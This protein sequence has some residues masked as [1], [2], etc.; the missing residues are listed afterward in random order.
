MGKEIKY[1][2]DDLPAFS[3][4]LESL[5]APPDSERAGSN[6][7]F[8]GAG[9]SF[10]A[11]K[12]A[13]YLSEFR[14]RALDPYDLLLNPRIAEGKHV[15]MISISG[16]TRTNIEAAKA[17]RGIARRITAITSDVRSVLAET[18]DDLIKLNFRKTGAVTPGT[19]SFTTTLLA[20]Y[21]R[22]RE[23]PAI[24]DLRE[25]FDSCVSWSDTI[26]LPTEGTV[27]IVG[28]GVSY[29][30]AIYG[31]AKIF[32]VLGSRS[33]YQAT[34]QF[35][36]MELFS[37]SGGDF[38]LLIPRSGADE[39]VA[40]LEG[41][42]AGGGWKVAKINPI[43]S[44]EVI[45]SILTAM[46]LQVLVWRTALK[47]GLEECSFKKKEKHLRISDAIIY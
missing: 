13:E 3:R 40:Q 7:I 47:L 11:A 34:E 28:T 1:Q 10:A 42:L 14:A 44:D 35:S 4:H 37:L 5:G 25:V 12:A 20:C 45:H 17:A 21:S 22:V 2:I 27:F 18:C 46:H 23:M 8:V 9:D 16:R 38:V 15:Y 29:C 6:C 30:M 43:E 19:V 31:A 32:E 33:Q 24:P 36:H 41:L 39:K 26:E